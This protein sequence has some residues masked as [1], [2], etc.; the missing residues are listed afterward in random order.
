MNITALP[1]DIPYPCGAVQA[2]PQDLM[3]DQAVF[4]QM[5][6]TKFQWQSH[7][8]QQPDQEDEL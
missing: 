1:E 3:K 7:D 4:S 6:V 5:R 8:G 2:L